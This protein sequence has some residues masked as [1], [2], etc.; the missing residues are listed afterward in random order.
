VSEAFFIPHPNKE[1]VWVVSAPGIV[2]LLAYSKWEAEEMV[3]ECD[4][5]LD[6]LEDLRAKYQNQETTGYP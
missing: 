3:R 2:Q 4:I 1:N 5:F 6:K